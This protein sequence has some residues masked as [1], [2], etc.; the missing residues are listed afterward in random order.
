MIKNTWKLAH[1]A[2]GKVWDY[3]NYWLIVSKYPVELTEIPIYLIDMVKIDR[4]R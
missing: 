4:F 3:L 1:S 2:A